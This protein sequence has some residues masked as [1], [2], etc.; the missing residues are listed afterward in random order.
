MDFVSRFSSPSPAFLF[1][2]ESADEVPA[3]WR[4]SH[5]AATCLAVL[6]FKL[7]ANPALRNLLLPNQTVTISLPTRNKERM[8]LLRSAVCRIIVQRKK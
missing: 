2:S 3:Q 5:R 6:E 4:D 8:P 7:R 1:A